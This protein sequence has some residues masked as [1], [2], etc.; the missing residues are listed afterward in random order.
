M[1]EH[2]CFK[3]SAEEYSPIETKTVPR[4]LDITRESWEETMSQQTE[5]SDQQ[6]CKGSGTRAGV[7][8]WGINPVADVGAWTGET[9]TADGYPLALSPMDLSMEVWRSNGEASTG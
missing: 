7:A 2:Q 4:H 8:D 5:T 6:S 3:S 9:T 1:R